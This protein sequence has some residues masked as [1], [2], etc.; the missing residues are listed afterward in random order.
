MPP[1]RSLIDL[2]SGISETGFLSFWAMMMRRVSTA[3]R[4]SSGTEAAG[5]APAAGAATAT[6][7]GAAVT[8]A[9][10]AGAASETGASA[11]SSSNW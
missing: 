11:A 5:P 3:L 7:T 10:E 2:L 8:G 9:A 4:G 1:T 6:A